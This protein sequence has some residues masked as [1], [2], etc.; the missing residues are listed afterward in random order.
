[1]IKVLFVCLGNICRSPAAEAIL[2]Q[3]V[4]D[5]KL[6]NSIEVRSCGLGH[7]HVGQPPDLRMQEASLK[8]GLKLTSIGQQFKLGFF[9]DYDYIL[10]ADQEVLTKLRENVKNDAQQKK[11]HLITE[12]SSNYAGM[13]VPDPYYSLDDGFELVL[14]MLQDSCEGLLRK[15]AQNHHKGHKGTQRGGQ[16]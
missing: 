14:D 6:S 16:F 9:D 2:R 10:A 1:M 8:R 4:A 3:Q 5:N 12:F 13:D 7:W 11:L 15:I